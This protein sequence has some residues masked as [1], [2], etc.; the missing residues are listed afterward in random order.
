MR[1]NVGDDDEARPLRAQEAT[2][3]CSGIRIDVITLTPSAPMPTGATTGNVSI[4][5][6]HA[7]QIHIDVFHFADKPDI[8]SVDFRFSHQQVPVR[9]G[10]ADRAA[11]GAQNATYN[12]LVDASGQNHLH[13]VKHRFGRF[14]QTRRRIRFRSRISPAL[15]KSPDR[16]RAR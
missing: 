10:K 15:P 1:G 16:L 3:P 2:A 9:A 14:A 13:D 12:F 7:D 11:A 5:Q 4:F 8:L 6:Q